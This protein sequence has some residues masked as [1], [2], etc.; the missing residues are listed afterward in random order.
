[1]TLTRIVDHGGWWSK[2]EDE[3]GYTGRGAPSGAKVRQYAAMIAAAPADAALMVGCSAD[4]AMQIYVSHAAATHGREGIVVVPKRAKRSAATEY[5]ASQGAEVVEVS[6]GYPAVY[7]KRMRDIAAERGLDVVRWDRRV[8]AHDTAE[9]VANL[10]AETRRVVVPTGSGLTAAGVIGGLSAAGRGDV[11]VV[12]ALVSTMTDAAGI[13]ATAE[14]MF[15][16]GLGVPLD[17][18]APRSKYGRAVS[19]SLPDGTGLDPYYAAKALPYVEP[20]DVL[21]ISGRRPGV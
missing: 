20:G 7:R 5:A 15:G 18:I 11:I 4:S 16:P 2:R 10:P 3:A 9:Q 14:N 19:G 6:P 21:W 8:A 12:A 13:A 1:M 17:A